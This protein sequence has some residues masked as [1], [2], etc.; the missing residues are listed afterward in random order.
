V[1]E[2]VEVGE[3]KQ[4][5]KGMG[6]GRKRRGRGSKGEREDGEVHEQKGRVKG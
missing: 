5:M 4:R 6:G 3:W 2:D 1:R